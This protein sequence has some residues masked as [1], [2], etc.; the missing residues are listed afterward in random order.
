[1][2]T[3][4]EAAVVA[5]LPLGAQ[6]DH[7]PDWKRTPKIPAVREQN[8]IA[9]ATGE[10][11]SCAGWGGGHAGD[12][13]AGARCACAPSM[14]F[15]LLVGTT[16]AFLTHCGARSRRGRPTHR[17]AKA[18]EIFT[19]V[20]RDQVATRPAQLGRLSTL[21][22]PRHSFAS[23]TQPLATVRASD[24]VAPR[25]LRLRGHP[26]I[27]AVSGSSRAAHPR[28]S[29]RRAL[30]FALLAG[31]SARFGTFARRKIARAHERVHVRGVFNVLPPFLHSGVVLDRED[32][33]IT[34]RASAPLIRS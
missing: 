17:P 26:A 29:V 4:A 5:K 21:V 19:R 10:D 11:C 33:S 30:L 16:I 2:L 32:V 1:M 31:R 28:G 23:W 12:R 25:G 7:V 3:N 14:G 24:T 22:Q 27:S 20:G 9:L 6:A 15:I 8:K 13:G 18:A 34:P